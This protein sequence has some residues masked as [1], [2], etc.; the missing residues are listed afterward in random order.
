MADLGLS[1]Q[2]IKGVFDEMKRKAQEMVDKAAAMRLDWD[3]S[4]LDMRNRLLAAREPDPNRDQGI[5]FN[6]S[7]DEFNRLQEEV[8]R[9]KPGT[10]AAMELA[11]SLQELQIE[12]ESTAT[13]MKEDK[14]LKSHGIEVVDQ[15]LTDMA[16]RLQTALDAL[17][18]EGFV[19][20]TE[21]EA[22]AAMVNATKDNTGATVELTGATRN[23]A[24]VIVGLPG[25]IAAAVNQAAAAAGA[26][27]AN[28]ISAQAAGVAG[29]GAP[30]INEYFQQ[31]ST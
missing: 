25:A 19:Q 2:D 24:G 28:A 11:K 20:Q 21:A 30:P 18:P 13:S 14:M 22:R 7:F 9:T 10:E 29:A 6:A 3:L 15:M 26:A 1:A 23:L 27:A 4:Q 5:D 17:N 16:T 31:G 8:K 12:A